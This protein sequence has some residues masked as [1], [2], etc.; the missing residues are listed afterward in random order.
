MTFL[1]TE[2]I[3][4]RAV[5]PED[6][7]VMY[8]IENNPAHWVV[9]GVTQ[10]IS[11]YTLKRYIESSND[12]LFID[13]QLRLM[14][15]ERGSREVVGIVDLTDYDPLHGRAAVGILVKSSHRKRGIGLQSLRLLRDYCFDFLHLHQLYAFIA[16]DNI[17][18]LNL[19]AHA[20]FSRSG[21]LKD[22]ISVGNV[23]K[24]VCV[25]QCFPACKAS[26]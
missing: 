8:A 24:T 16:T 10:P 21:E 25:M 6:L 11:M 19:F 17:P 1:E 2:Y 15:V 12:D 9:G 4:L 18:S 7:D 26:R 13:R 3:Y 23:Y 20:G 5:E 22:W 14:I